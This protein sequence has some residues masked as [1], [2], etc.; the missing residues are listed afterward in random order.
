MHSTR[1]QFILIA[2]SC[3]VPIPCSIHMHHPRHLVVCD[4]RLRCPR[5][6]KRHQRGP[7]WKRILQAIA[8][9]VEM[10]TAMPSPASPAPVMVGQHA[11]IISGCN[12]DCRYFSAIFNLILSILLPTQCQHDPQDQATKVTV[13]VLPCCTFPMRC[14]L[15]LILLMDISHERDSLPQN[16]ELFS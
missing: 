9:R 4:F 8:E 16:R 12:F 3:E 1:E 15:H 11:V 13:R 2:C 6:A 14:I 10:Q 5:R 7:T